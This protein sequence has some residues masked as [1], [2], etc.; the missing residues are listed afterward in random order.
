M[1]KVKTAVRTLIALILLAIIVAVGG[2]FI[3]H[4]YIEKNPLDSVVM[5]G[6]LADAAEL[7]VQTLSVTDIF[8][9]TTGNIPL[10]TKNKYLVKY[11]ATV[12]AGFDVSK[13]QAECDDEKITVKIPHCTI[14]E[15]SVNVR[16]KDI[17]AYDTNF[18]LFSPTEKEVLS[19]VETAEK[20]A[21]EFAQKEESGLLQAAD[22]NALNIVKG[23]FIG[24]AGGRTV[25]VEFL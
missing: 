4:K 1:S 25:E 19:M 11:R 8:E 14:D 18:A 17:K 21:L 20:H 9:E 13:A 5:E 22:A 3:Y 23:L 10:I 12:Y 15:D 7:T 16:G 24:V 6:I 2:N